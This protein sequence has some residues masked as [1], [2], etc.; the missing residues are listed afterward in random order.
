MARTWKDKINDILT[1]EQEKLSQQYQEA[2]ANWADTGYE[3]YWKKLNKTEEQLAQI[4]SFRNSGL[5]LA[6]AESEIRNIKRAIEKYRNKLNEEKKRNPC[7][8]AFERLSCEFMI[9]FEK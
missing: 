7:N 3:R 5:E 6:R 8:E 1:K 4:E 2:Y 9:L